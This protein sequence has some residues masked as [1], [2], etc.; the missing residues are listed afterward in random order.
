MGSE[1][2]TIMRIGLPLGVLA[3]GVLG[4]GAMV[5]MR[6]DVETRRPE[7]IPPWSGSRRSSCMRSSSP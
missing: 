7:A 3:I 1:R 2:S 4:A 6:P 5:M